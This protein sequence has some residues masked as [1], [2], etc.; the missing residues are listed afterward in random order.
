VLNTN[1]VVHRIR[2]RQ[3]G[4]PVFRQTFD[5]SVSTS[6]TRRLLDKLK[7]SGV[8]GIAEGDVV[9]NLGGNLFRDIT[10]QSKSK[11]ALIMGTMSSLEREQ[12][13]SGV[14]R[15]VSLPGYRGH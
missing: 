9:F 11:D 5:H 12:R 1:N 3:K 15:L 14:N 2:A 6:E 13:L 8:F 7:I 10:W 4:I